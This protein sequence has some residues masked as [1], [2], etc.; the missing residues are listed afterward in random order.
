MD[1]RHVILDGFNIIF[2]DHQLNRQFRTSQDGAKATLVEMARQV[3]DTE[4]LQMSIVFDGKG[5][6]I[7]IEHPSRDTTFSIIYSSSSVSADGVIE[8]MLAR[9]KRTHDITVVSNDGL[10]QNAARASGAE[11][12]RVDDFTGWVKGC[13]RKSRVGL[14]RRQ[15]SAQDEWSNRLPL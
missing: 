13:E 8:R 1:S 4:H 12:M 9:S 15:S 5:D 6:A 7:S 2:G 14:S 3:Y 11:T 10:V